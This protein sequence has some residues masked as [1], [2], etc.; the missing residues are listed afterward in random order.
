ME[1]RHSNHDLWVSGLEATVRLVCAFRTANEVDSSL[2]KGRHAE[3][4]DLFGTIG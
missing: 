1:S 4:R 2:S 3:S